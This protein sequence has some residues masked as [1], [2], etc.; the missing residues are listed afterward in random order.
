MRDS[1]I[2]KRCKLEHPRLQ[3]LLSQ[4]RQ[5]VAALATRL[6]ELTIVD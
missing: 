6:P 1:L 4:L 5:R 3:G 2:V